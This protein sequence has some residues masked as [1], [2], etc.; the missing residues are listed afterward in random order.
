MLITSKVEILQLGVDVLQL[1]CN[2]TTICCN[3]KGG[4]FGVVRMVKTAEWKAWVQK[5]LESKEKRLDKLIK[6]QVKR[7][8]D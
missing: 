6:R 8:E 2:W 7:V 1:C 3:S 5:R 4:R